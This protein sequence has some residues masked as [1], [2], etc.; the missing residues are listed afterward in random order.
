M[1][2]LVFSYLIHCPASGARQ[3]WIRIQLAL[4]IRVSFLRN[5]CLEAGL[6]QVV[7]SNQRGPDLVSLNKE[8]LAS[9]PGYLALHC[10][11]SG[12]GGLLRSTLGLGKRNIGLWVCLGRP[13]AGECLAI[14]RHDNAKKKPRR[15]GVR[16]L[17]EQH[18]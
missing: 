1:Q 12:S 8:G 2:S 16:Y 6:G 5:P 13:L 3:R 7:M 4:L 18:V 15:G 10:L 14:V 17:R 9:L 11:G